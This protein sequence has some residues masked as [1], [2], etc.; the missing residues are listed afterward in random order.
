MSGS[1]KVSAIILSYVPYGM[2]L[3]GYW[4][5]TSFFI[6][7]NFKQ[8]LVFCIEIHDRIHEIHPQ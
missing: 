4:F 1:Y 5:S 7:Q 6:F 8:W 3:T 2:A